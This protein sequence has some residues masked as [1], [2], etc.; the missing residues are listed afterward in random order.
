[1]HNEPFW[2]EGTST[3]CTLQ[4]HVRSIN[5]AFVCAT[6][7]GLKG[8]VSVVRRA[9]RRDSRLL[10]LLIAAICA[11][12]GRLLRQRRALPLRHRPRDRE[13]PDTRGPAE[14]ALHCRLQR[15]CADGR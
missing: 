1:M 15:S 4:E 8:N 5:C 3:L 2:R 13:G 7:E 11:A 6:P 12:A 14:L 9:V 10:G